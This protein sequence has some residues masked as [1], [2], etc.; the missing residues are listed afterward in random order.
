MDLPPSLKTEKSKVAYNSR[1]GNQPQIIL[2]SD[3]PVPMTILSI[4]PTTSV[5]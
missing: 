1:W 3:Q 2:M 5:N 4:T